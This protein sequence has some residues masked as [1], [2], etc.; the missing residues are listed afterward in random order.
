MKHNLVKEELIEDIAYSLGIEDIGLATI[1]E[2]VTLV[3]K[4]E[5]ETGEKFIR[6][7]MGVPSL[8]S[9]EI[10]TNAEIEALKSG[11]AS[12]Y[13]MLDGLPALKREAS[14]FFEAFLNVKLAPNH[15]VPVVGTMQGTFA[16]FVAVSQAMPEKDHILFIDPG[17]PV[18]KQQLQVLGLKWKT[19]DVYNYR[20]ES[21]AGKLDEMLGDG[22]VS[23][24]IYSNPNNPSWICFT[25]DE[26]KII[27]KKADQYNVIV[28]EDLAYFGMDFR[29]N[30]GEPYEP[31]FQPSVANYT[32]NYILHFSSS[33]VFSYAGQRIGLTAISDTLFERKFQALQTRYG[34]ASLGAV[35]INRLL[36]ALSSGTSHSAQYALCAMLKAANQRQFNFI[37]QLKVY[38]ERARVMKSLFLSN[39]FHLVYDK[40]LDVE[41]ADGFYFTVAYKE[42][43]GAD[44][45]EKLIYYGISAMALAPTGSIQQG[46]RACTSF[47][48]EDQFPDLEIRLK[49]FA[50]DY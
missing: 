27:A 41:L 7:E 31:P 34:I 44:L 28:I 14:R 15:I 32:K 26:L 13:P 10:G 12:K 25:E 6:M 3:N 50:N 43:S 33:K 38:G 48:T 21:L 24:L 2:I 39:G 16:S 47:V 37:D 11:V 19:F 5:A 36:Y 35:Y 18:Q 4:T 22:T 29:Q 20:G 9:P 1:R 49:A 45:A 42:M 23:C 8:P 17:F 40:D 46:I 30:L